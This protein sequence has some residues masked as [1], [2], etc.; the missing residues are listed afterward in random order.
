MARTIL[1]PGRAVIAV[2]L[3]VL[4]AKAFILDFAVVDGRS[5]LPSLEPGSVVL[6]LRCAYGLSRPFGGGY[7]ATWAS[8]RR[9]DLVAGSNP[10]NGEAIVKRAAAVGPATLVVEAGRL[11]GPGID[12]ELRGQ[13]EA[14]LGPNPKVPR[15]SLFLLGDNPGESIDSRDYG[16]VPIESLSGKVLSFR[17][18][19]PQ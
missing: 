6:V 10:R 2:I 11:L 3:S 9:G 1:R 13:A 4:F 17:S 12:V 15:G 7:L 18:W 5:M 14:G 8:P 19:A 16:S